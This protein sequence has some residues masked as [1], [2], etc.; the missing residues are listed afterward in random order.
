MGIVA[1]YGAIVEGTVLGHV[2]ADFW[3]PAAILTVVFLALHLTIRFVAKYA[4]PIL[5]PA[6]ALLNGVGVAFLRRLDLSPEAG[7]T[8][9]DLTVFAGLGG[10]QLAWTLAA[11]VSAIV[12]LLVVRDHR[13]VSK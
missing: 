13:T 9:T 5:L 10:R 12:L 1:A 8:V 11:V 3:V 7:E 2:T 4:D 6:V